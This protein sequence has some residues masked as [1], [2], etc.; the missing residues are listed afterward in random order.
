MTSTVCAECQNINDGQHAMTHSANIA[1]NIGQKCIDA[2]K[3]PITVFLID[4]IF[5]SREVVR[6]RCGDSLRPIHSFDAFGTH[7]VNTLIGAHYFMK[8]RCSDETMTTSASFAPHIHSPLYCQTHFVLFTASFF[9]CVALILCALLKLN[10]PRK[11]NEIER[12]RRV[13]A[14]Q[15]THALSH[16][17]RA[18]NECKTQHPNEQNGYTAKYKSKKTHMPRTYQISASK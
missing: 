13:R 2:D 15:Y 17:T 5:D 12:R 9:F 7:R 3:W 6:A 18:T 10:F 8:T 14:P 11:S 16:P 4:T 1:T